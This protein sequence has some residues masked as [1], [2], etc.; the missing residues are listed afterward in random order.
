MMVKRIVLAAS[1]AA[2]ISGPAWALPGLAPAHQGKGAP[3]TTPNNGDN[4]GSSNRSAEGNENAGG[5]GKHGKG[6]H[7]NGNSGNPTKP[8][9][10]HK[11]TPRRVAY[12]A[13]GRLVLK[14]KEASLTTLKKNADGTYSG[15]VT[16][17]V[18]QTNRHAAADKGKM[19][20]YKVEHVRVTFGLADANADGNVGLD[21]LKAGDRVKLI[22]KITALAKKCAKGEFTPTTTI[23]KVV[24]HG[25]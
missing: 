24:F 1:A 21:D 19:T 4:Q 3:S 10:S 23:R 2:L 16:V 20:T 11:C 14:E 18:K 22:G 6:H 12:V 9:N 15:E 8:G 7:G 5:K 13:S 17:D 25:P